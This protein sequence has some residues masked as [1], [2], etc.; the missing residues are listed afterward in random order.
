[1]NTQYAFQ[2]LEKTL[3][4]RRPHGGAS[5]AAFSIWLIDQLPGCRVDTAGNIHFPVGL[6]RTLF[7]AHVDT[8]HERS[9]SN[10]FKRESGRW[11]GCGDV[12]GADDG[13]GVALLM[14]M[15]KSGVPGHYLFTQG[16]EQGCIG[17][18]CLAQIEGDALRRFDHAIAFDRKGTSSVITHQRS[19][20]TCSDEFAQRLASELNGCGTGLSLHPDPTGFATDTC[21]FAHLIA[22]CTNVSVGYWNAH[23]ENEWLDLEYFEAICNAVVRLDWEQLPTVRRP[24]GAENGGLR[25]LSHATPMPNMA[26][27]DVLVEEAI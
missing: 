16:E 24:S 3:S 23:T 9:G 12:L 2:V 22:E 15:I 4:V 18:T 27:R 14:H 1:M 10:H 11:I 13:A 7:C 20:R 8:V 21:E 17:S 6:S 25:W 5:T 26:A 19:E